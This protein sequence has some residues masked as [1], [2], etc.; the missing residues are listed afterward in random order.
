MSLARLTQSDLDRIEAELLAIDHALDVD[1]DEVSVVDE[2]L[3]RLEQLEFDV[4][5]SLKNLQ[6]SRLR[7]VN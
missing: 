5:Q 6:R 7:I 3:E 4:M 2:N 1:G